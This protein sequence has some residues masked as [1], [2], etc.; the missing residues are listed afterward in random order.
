M[1]HEHKRGIFIAGGV[2]LFEEVAAVCH[3]AVLKLSN[4]AR[5]GVRSPFKVK[6]LTN[7]ADSELCPP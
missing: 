1:G 4:L 2:V 5:S 7:V 6:K 3:V